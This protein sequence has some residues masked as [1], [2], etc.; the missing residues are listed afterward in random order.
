VGW[1]K[2]I[3]ISAGA[4]VVFLFFGA[5]APQNLVNFINPFPPNLFGINEGALAVLERVTW[6]AYSI[7]LLCAFASILSLILRFIRSRGVERQQ[8][9]WF[10]F[11]AF[12][13]IPTIL[14][15]LLGSS[16][17]TTWAPTVAAIGALLSV[18]V[19]TGLPVTATLA[20]LRYRLW[21]IDIIIRRT[22]IYGLLSTSLALVYLL[23]V[24]LLQQ[25]LLAM[26]E[27]QRL[28]N[29]TIVAS[30]LLTVALITPLRRRS[31]DII[32]RRFY[33]HKYDSEEILAHFSVVARDKI[34]LDELTDELLNTIQ[35]TL[36]PE[37]LTMWLK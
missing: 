32:D 1:R 4:T 15:L 30:T 17:E 13:F 8:L 36:Q 26:T 5:I 24:V 12:L 21:D 34:D 27:Q 23:S 25:V 18:I 9:K 6:G 11:S 10:A 37:K 33:R 19:V 28:G 14:L 20:I 7:M 2:L 31:Q 22:L 35:V 29:W 16:L 3:W